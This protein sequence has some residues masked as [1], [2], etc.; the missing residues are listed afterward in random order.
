MRITNFGIIWTIVLFVAAIKGSRSLIKTIVFSSIF[1]AGAVIVVGTKASLSPL[2]C[3][4]IVYCLRYV[5]VNIKR[6][7]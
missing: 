5:F 6:N 4:C 7:I 1:Q 2:A 3:S